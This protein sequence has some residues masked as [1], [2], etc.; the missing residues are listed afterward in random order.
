MSLDILAEAKKVFDIEIQELIRLKENLDENFVKA[1][2]I[3]LSCEGKVITTGVGKSGHIAQKIASTLS[4]TGTPAHF[5]HPSEALHGDLGVI[6]QRDVL[7]AISNSGESPEVIS[8]IPYVKLL[9]VPIIAITNRKDSTLAKY[10]DVHIFLNVQKEACPLELA[11]T[12]S[13]TASLLVGD[14]LAMVL[15]Q[16]KGF[17]KE[18]FALRHPGGSLGRRLRLVRDL[19]HTGDEVPIVYEDTPMTDVIIE[20]TSKGFGATAVIDKDGKLVGIITDGD[21][22]RFV[23]NGGDFNTAKARDVMTKTP[24]T[25]KANELA[26]E[27]LK[28]MEDHKITVLIVIDDEGRP[29]GIIHMH[30]I[31]KAGVL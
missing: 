25:A 31:L 5:L 28:R 14:A 6:D 16:L 26:V 13:S 21:L 2:E 15:L 23:K 7:L 19:Y 24:K 20:M 30:D 4:S 17:T 3:L 9:K 18:D 11:P 10:A 22:R 29:E 8:L 12:S 1:V 27:A